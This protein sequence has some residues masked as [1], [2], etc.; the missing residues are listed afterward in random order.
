MQVIWPVRPTH[1]SIQSAQKALQRPDH[2]AAY[3]RPINSEVKRG[4]IPLLPTYLYR[5]LL[6]YNMKKPYN[7]RDTRRSF[8]Y[9]AYVA[10]PFPILPNLR[11][12]S[13]LFSSTSSL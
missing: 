2:E 10:L 7:Y 8:Y 1:P 4:A 13:A 12:S 5:M 9:A 6:N 11:D 3:S